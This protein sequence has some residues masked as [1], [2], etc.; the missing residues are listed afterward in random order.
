MNESGRR[1]RHFVN[2]KKSTTPF[3]VLRLFVP[4]HSPAKISGSVPRI[5]ISRCSTGTRTLAGSAV[6]D[7]SS[8]QTSP[9]LSPLD[10]GRV[11]V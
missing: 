4:S 7:M 3:P 6:I 9:Y 5:G 11:G 10:L 1:Q 8:P 2:S